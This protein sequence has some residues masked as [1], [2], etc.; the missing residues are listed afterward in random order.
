MHFQADH[1]AWES[2]AGQRLDEFA[3]RL[4]SDP[5]LEICVFGS[6]PLQLF[7]DPGFFSADIDIFGG[8][9]THDRLLDFVAQQDWTQE[10]SAHFYIQVCDPLAFKSTIDWRSRAI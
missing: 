6:A 2:P 10:K 7:M 4:P 3:R 5:R 9:S 8:E 1:I